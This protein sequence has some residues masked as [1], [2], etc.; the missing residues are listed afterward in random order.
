MLRDLARE[1]RGEESGIKEQDHLDDGAEQRAV[2]RTSVQNVGLECRF[3]FNL[4]G[5]ATYKSFKNAAAE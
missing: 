5:S 2:H 1:T 3:W 4:R